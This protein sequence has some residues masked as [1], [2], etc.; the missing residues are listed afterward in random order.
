MNTFALARG[1]TARALA[2][3]AMLLMLAWGEAL[4]CTDGRLRYVV[5]DYDAQR[6]LIA[7]GVLQDSV[8]EA[9]CNKLQKALHL[10][11]KVYGAPV[12]ETMAEKVEALK[13]RYD[14]FVAAF[15]LKLVGDA[16][17]EM[18][19]PHTLVQLS[20]QNSTE[21]FYRSKLKDVTIYTYRFGFANNRP[22]ARLRD[23]ITIDRQQTVKEIVLSPR[24]FRLVNEDIRNA[25]TVHRIRRAFAFGR[26]LVGHYVYFAD[27][28]IQEFQTPTYLKPLIAYWTPPREIL[29]NSD[30]AE[31]ATQLKAW[32]SARELDSVQETELLAASAGAAEAR[33]PAAIDALLRRWAWRRTMAAIAKLSASSLEESLHRATTVKVD[34]C[35]RSSRDRKYRVVFATNRAPTGTLGASLLAGSWFRAAPHDKDKLTIGCA[36]VAT[37]AFDD[38]VK[39]APVEAR[40][41]EHDKVAEKSATKFSTAQARFVGEVEQSAEQIKIVDAE[42]WRYPDEGHALVYV[43]GFNNSF[44]TALYTAGQIAAATE[45]KGRIYMFSWP[46]AESLWSYMEDMD[47]AES[48]E[49][50]FTKFVR[51]IL[52]DPEVRRI[53]LVAHSMG[54]QIVTRSLNVLLEEFQVR[55]GVLLGRV[56]L[57]APDIST[58]V[59]AAKVRA[60]SRLGADIT[61]YGSATDSALLASA[62]ARDNNRRLGLIVG[63]AVP[64][65]DK[66]KFVDATPQHNVCTAWGYMDI[67]HSY[68][69]ENPAVLKHTAALLAGGGAESVLVTPSADKKYDILKSEAPTC[70]WRWGK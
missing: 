31:R 41:A 69:T 1:A 4:A 15:D 6:A 18:L 63:N 21:A 12:A 45:Y 17:Q 70:W 34:N 59:F 23:S 24:D 14:E 22:E 30:D 64:V 10:Y 29:D 65:I 27:A 38:A 3:T 62:R 40:S 46:S 55:K 16:G 20:D 42:R 52:T 36:L 49:A 47:S 25:Q 57:A 61:V 2:V 53:D 60:I 44:E 26:S 9:D 50:H 48:A 35:L 7:A 19:V 66:V 28:P 32:A 13:P 5:S 51:A 11:D 56:I 39:A 8:G 67:G 33:A 54:A 68:L 58:D 37:P 43:H